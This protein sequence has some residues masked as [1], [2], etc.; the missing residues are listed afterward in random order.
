M[1]TKQAR[2]NKAKPVVK[3]KHVRTRP[4]TTE[5]L[6]K[7]LAPL[8]TKA[9]SPLN[10][11]FPGQPNYTGP[12]DG[13]FSMLHHR[14]LFEKAD[15]R[16]VMDRVN[17]VKNQKPFHELAVRLKNIVYLGDCPAVRIM[18]KL[19]K[20]RT[21]LAD[22][23]NKMAREKNSDQVNSPYHELV[24]LGYQVANALSMVR[25]ASTDAVLK[26]LEQV[27]PDHDWNRQRS[28]INGT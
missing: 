9:P 5:A 16:G 21:A 15:Q 23:A 12:K 20:T 2:L 13:Y 25:D 26:Y 27:L 10:L 11:L 4:L 14:V 1:P 22:L 19:D 7:A 18:G 28:I 8:V 17:Y 24:D 6:A 3:R